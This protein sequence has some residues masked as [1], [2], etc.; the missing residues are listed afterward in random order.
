MG[1]YK[2]MGPRLAWAASL[3]ALASPSAAVVLN[4]GA[5]CPFATVQDAVDAIPSG[6]VHEIHIKAGTYPAQAIVIASRHITLHGGHADCSGDALAGTTTLSGAGG[7][8]D[9]V[10]TVTGG[11]NVVALEHLAVTQGDEVGDGYGGGIDFRGAG[12]LTLRDTTISDSYAGYGG[13]I[14]VS[15]SGGLAELWLEDGSIIV[16]NTAQFS[17]GGIRV[18]GDARVYMLDHDVWLLWNTALGFD[19]DN[20]QFLYGYGGG[21]EVIGPADADIAGWVYA[22]TARYGGG[23]AVI[24]GEGADGLDA[25][26]R[27]FTTDPNHPVA[28]ADNRATQ[29][30]G[31]IWLKPNHHIS[32]IDFYISHAVFCAFDFRI[33][34]N[35]AQQG[36]A[37]YADTDADQ[38]ANYTGSTAS[39]N[40]NDCGPEPRSSLG[41][42]GCAAN[43]ACNTINAN[44]SD[45]VN[46]QATAG[47]SILIQTAGQLDM[48]QVT[49]RHNHAAQV[50]RAI[51]AGAIR[52]QQCVIAD[53][54]M[55]GPLI[56][57]EQDTS[58]VVIV[59]DTMAN[60]TI[61]AAHV[62]SVDVNYD[63]VLARSILWHPGK[64]SLVQAGGSRTVEYVV[65][66]DRDSL[67]AGSA[68]HVIEADPRFED[69]AQGDYRPIAA[70]PA[71]DAAFFED[72]PGPDVDIDGNPRGYD[73]P[74][75][76]DF[77]GD[78]DIGAYERQG[79]FSMV[80]NHS[81]AVDMHLWTQVTPAA[82]IWEAVG[83]GGSG[84]V[85]IHKELDDGGVEGRAAGSAGVIGLSQ[86]VRIPGPGFYQLNGFG[87]TTSGWFSDSARLHWKLRP[88]SPGETCDGTVVSE[89][90]LYLPSGDTYAAPATPAAI[91]IS[92]AQW[93]TTTTVEIQTVVYEG[94]ITPIGSTDGWFDRITLEP[95]PDT[96][97]ADGFEM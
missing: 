95:G 52:M 16:S 61:G 34:E 92:E 21:I 30:G 24:G 35:H 64:T 50:V 38:V 57:A 17:G 1:G 66:S 74:I 23:I 31:G 89:G 37:I 87:H 55:T 9:S 96:L 43:V 62:L 14:N 72:N 56:Q 6:G 42:T 86:C 4:V 13:G 36:S 63:L 26:V 10:L 25:T 75:V 78:A 70:S 20:N 80:R 44:T 76:P 47:A 28:V 85:H 90:D 41:A 33:D 79:T 83:A 29:T 7:N 5:G 94:G 22:N 49:L 45:N 39:F 58:T 65:T 91:V 48:R 27:L 32:G 51:G 2:N 59:G 71:V 19:P 11:D 69:P 15:A 77:Y 73:I 97:F 81:F 40:D 82:V 93:T 67:V 53:N 46:G 84:G 18:E 54:T 3:L 8:P 60:N 68:P 88:S 12:S